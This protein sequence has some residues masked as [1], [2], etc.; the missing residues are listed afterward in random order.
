MAFALGRSQGQKEAGVV[1]R[2][3][4]SPRVRGGIVFFGNR[5]HRLGPRLGKPL[6]N[7]EECLL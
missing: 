7:L 1:L 3:D 2:L 4:M 6:T 5:L